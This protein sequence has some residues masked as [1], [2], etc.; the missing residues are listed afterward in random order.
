MHRN[1][2]EPCEAYLANRDKGHIDMTVRGPYTDRFL[3]KRLHKSA[4]IPKQLDFQEE[5]VKRVPISQL[6]TTGEV[7]IWEWSQG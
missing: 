7:S 6:V 4:A 5:G 2:T 3:T 1:P